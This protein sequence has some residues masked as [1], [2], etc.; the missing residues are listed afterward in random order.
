MI[1]VEINGIKFNFHSMHPLRLCIIQLAEK[2][3]ISKKLLT[4]VRWFFQH[5]K[6]IGIYRI[7]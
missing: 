4:Q 6:N 7:W 5:L 1:I 3:D 2:F